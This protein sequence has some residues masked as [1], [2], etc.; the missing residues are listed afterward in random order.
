MALKNVAKGLP[1]EL[2]EY[3]SFDDDTAIAST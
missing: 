1:G 2:C 3:A